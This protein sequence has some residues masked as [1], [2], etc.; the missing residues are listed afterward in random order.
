[1]VPLETPLD[2]PDAPAEA[3]ARAAVHA[4]QAVAG[5][6]GI[7]VEGVVLRARDAGD[8]I[9]AEITRRGAE[10]VG[11]ATDW[12]RAP[13]AARLLPETTDHV[14]RHAPCRVVLIGHPT[15]DRGS[16]LERDGEPVFHAGRP[17]DYWPTGA[18]V[19]RDAA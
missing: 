6:Y 12:Q 14:L 18:F 3:A 10:V 15:D 9:V 2:V 1:E 17:S 5:R 13:A 19:D 4:A 16:R 11:V 7:P 8:A